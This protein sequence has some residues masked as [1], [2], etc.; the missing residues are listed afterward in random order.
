MTDESRYLLA[1]YLETQRRSA[2]VSPGRVADQL[3]RSPAAVT[4]MLQRMAERGLVTY[5]PYEGATLTPEGR[6]RGADYY[7]TYT[8]LVQ[9]FEEVLELE[10]PETEARQFATVVSPEVADRLA[11]TLLN[12]DGLTDRS[13]QSS[14]A[15][16]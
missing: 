5:E 9:F 10:E 2:P 16:S 13:E 12:P 3:D 14:S 8:V 4:E 15:E 11:A 7:E 1:L 6:S